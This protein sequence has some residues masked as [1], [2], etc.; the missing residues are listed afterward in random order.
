VLLVVPNS[1][2][3]NWLREL[4]RW[5]PDVI[6]RRVIGAAEDRLATYRL[7]IKLL[8]VSFEQLREDYR[9]ISTD[10]QFD[11][12]IVDE[13][14]RI[15]NSS[16]EV[17]LACRIIPR[18]CAWALTGTPV[19]NRPED[20]ISIYR[21]IYPGLLHVGMSR[22]EIHNRIRPHF[23]RRTRVNSEPNPLAKKHSDEGN[24]HCFARSSVRMRRTTAGAGRS[25]SALMHKSRTMV[26]TWRRIMKALI[27]ALALATLIAVPTLAQPAIAAPV[28]PASSSFRSN[29]Y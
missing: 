17:S 18:R 27:A 3:L 7:P 19:E 8:I 15:K 2:C 29:G 12:A 26:Q 6:A 10:R 4:S 21:F 13:A 24:K 20:L 28:S 1:L 5:T 25:A 11:L 23:L 9:H 14:Q 16:S 22:S